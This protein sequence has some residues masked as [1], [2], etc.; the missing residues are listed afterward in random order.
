MHLVTSIWKR[1]WNLQLLTLYCLFRNLR[2]STSDFSAV[3]ADRI[4]VA[5][6]IFRVSRTI[7][8]DVLNVFWRDRAYYRSFSKNKVLFMVRCFF[9][10]IHFLEDHELPESTSHILSVP[11]NLE[12]A[13]ILSW[14]IAFSSYFNC[15]PDD[16]LCKIAFWVYYN[17]LNSLC[18]KPC[19]LSQ[20]VVIW[21]WKYENAIPGISEN[22]ILHPSIYWYVGNYYIFTS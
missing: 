12:C 19:D 18:D 17:A 8:L 21:S 5:L 11:L 6:N 15:F 4:F 13:R 16:V 14:S 3:D 10:L 20:K 9:L 7:I 22:S 2:C 1:L